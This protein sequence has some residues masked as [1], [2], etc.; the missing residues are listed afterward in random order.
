MPNFRMR[1]RIVRIV[2]S[3]FSKMSSPKLQVPSVSVAI[4]GLSSSAAMRSSTPM[5]TA[6]PVENCWRIGQRARIA[7][8]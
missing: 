2:G 1:A 4:S 5:P 8:E 6:P 7:A 3:E